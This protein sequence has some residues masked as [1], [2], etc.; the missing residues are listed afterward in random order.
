MSNAIKEKQ[1]TNVRSP[2]RPHARLTTNSTRLCV[3]L[4]TC[5]Y[6]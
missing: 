6:T 3:K 2:G 5:V 4:R 1:Q